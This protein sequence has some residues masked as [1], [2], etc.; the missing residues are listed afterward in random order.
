MRT[1]LIGRT[2]LLTSLLLAGQ[3]HAHKPILSDGTAVDAEHAIQIDDIAVSYVVYHEV[4]DG[5]K[6]LWIAF[7][8]VAGQQVYA[9]LGIPMIDRLKDYRPAV[10]LVGP[11][12]PSSTLPFSLPEGLGAQILTDGT[13]LT[14]SPFHEPFTGTDSWILGQWT[15]T[16]PE[17]GK[18]Y[19]V[20][21]VPGGQ[22]GKLWLATGQKEA[23]TLDDIAGLSATIQRVRAFHEVPAAGPPCFLLPMATGL[24]VVGGLQLTRGRRHRLASFSGEGA[25]AGRG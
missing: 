25:L 10:A 7:N 9:Q 3:A 2:V 23:F 6:Q 19:F 13:G 16:L 12:L 22:P 1:R 24:L 20:V 21:Y 17:A 8:A 15:P 18:Y 5:T 11:G 14:P 4:T